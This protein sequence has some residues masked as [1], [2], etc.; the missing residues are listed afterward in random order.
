MNESRKS[1]IATNKRQYYAEV[2]RR[3]VGVVVIIKIF[4]V[5]NLTT[6]QHERITYSVTPVRTFQLK[7]TKTY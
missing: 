6:E 4:D 1:N 7:V 3:S 2:S 5:D